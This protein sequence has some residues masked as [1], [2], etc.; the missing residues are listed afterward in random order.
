[1]PL[2]FWVLAAFLP[3]APDLDAFSF[4]A[5]GN[6]W[7]HRG[8]TH[9][10][11]FAVVLGA[12]TAALTFRYF[13]V[14]FW[15]LAAFFV[16]ITASHGLLDAFTFGGAGIPFF[17]PMTARRFGPWGP[18]PLPIGME[19][20]NPWKHPSVRAEL[21]Y[22]WLPTIALVVAVDACRVWRRRWSTAKPVGT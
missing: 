17:W 6:I 8:W 15:L 21:L 12:V 7:G 9:S 16:L 14:N 22:V 13:R 19:I 10:L 2:L 11:I 5:Y 1:M 3:A 4:Y 20:P 18:V